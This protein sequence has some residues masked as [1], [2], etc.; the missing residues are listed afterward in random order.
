MWT[1][2]W[3]ICLTQSSISNNCA[4][5]YQSL[6]DIFLYKNH[7][8]RIMRD[9]HKFRV[10]SDRENDVKPLRWPV[11]ISLKGIPRGFFFYMN[12]GCLLH[13]GGVSH[14]E[15]EQRLRLECQ[16]GSEM[17]TSVLGLQKMILGGARPLESHCAGPV[18]LKSAPVHTRDK[19]CS[20]TYILY[21]SVICRQFWIKYVI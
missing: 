19:R 18:T 16:W 11:V 9:C 1:L 5:V 21:C 7:K 4:S 12:W 2:K 3:I 14:S 6:N 13:S 20:S 17:T 15:P 10:Q 8:T